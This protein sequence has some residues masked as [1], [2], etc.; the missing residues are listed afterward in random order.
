[1]PWGTESTKLENCFI[2]YDV[3]IFFPFF[4]EFPSRGRFQPLFGCK[5]IF[6][7]Q[8]SKLQPENIGNDAVKRFPGL[9]RRRGLAGLFHFSS[10]WACTC[11]VSALVDISVGG[12]NSGSLGNLLV[13]KEYYFTEV[14]AQPFH[15]FRKNHL[16]V[17]YR[18]K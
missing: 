2:S 16:N 6:A 10:P 17:S 8:F 15:V 5:C 3:D 7:A 9:E 1:M 13:Q 4:H 14:P 11:E 12:V 18:R